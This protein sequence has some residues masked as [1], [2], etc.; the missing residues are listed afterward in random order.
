M[1]RILEKRGFK[2]QAKANGLRDGTT[3]FKISWCN[4]GDE[5]AKLIAEILKSNN[6]ITKLDLRANKIGDVGAKALAE[7]VKINNFLTQL[8]LN[9]IP[10]ASTLIKSIDEKIKYNK[11]LVKKLAVFLKKCFAG[12]NNSDFFKNCKC[13]KIL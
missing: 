12:E 2:N 11:K 13:R 5:G 10:G 7:A 4:I 1:N 6:T 8:D 3:K 9:E